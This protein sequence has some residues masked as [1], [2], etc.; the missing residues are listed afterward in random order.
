MAS[1]I[2]MGD[3]PEL[4]ENI[5]NNLKNDP[6]SLYSCALASRHWCKMSIPILWQNPFSFIITLYSFLNI[7]HPLTKTKYTF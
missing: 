3:M 5:L 6:N 7:F 4:M 1:K 2:L